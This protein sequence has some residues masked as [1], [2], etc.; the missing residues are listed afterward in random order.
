MLACA[1]HADRCSY[2]PTM[3]PMLSPKQ[4]DGIWGDRE[5]PQYIGVI[6]LA[7][8]ESPEPLAARQPL[9]HTP[10]RYEQCAPQIGSSDE[11][12]GM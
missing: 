4:G 10:W 8:R 3:L 5:K 9:C 11:Q 12:N 2:V 6:S 1:L 7:T